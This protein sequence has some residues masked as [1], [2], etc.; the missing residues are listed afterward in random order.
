[1]S[2]NR[3]RPESIVG[4]GGG[5]AGDGTMARVAD[6]MHCVTVRFHVPTDN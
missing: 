5:G 4:G 1:M 2:E 6:S 3:I